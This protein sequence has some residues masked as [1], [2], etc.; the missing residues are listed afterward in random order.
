MHN[1]EPFIRS[2]SKWWKRVFSMEC[3]ILNAYNFES[4]IRTSS[5]KEG[6]FL[7]FILELAKAL[8]FFKNHPGNALYD[9]KIYKGKAWPTQSFNPE[10]GLLPQFVE[11]KRRCVVCQVRIKLVGLATIGH[12]CDIFA[13]CRHVWHMG[14]TTTIVPHVDFSRH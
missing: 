3:S 12:H 11:I 4:F 2:I 9:L 8:I 14:E 5:N 10:L 13:E 7:S 1:L 6:H